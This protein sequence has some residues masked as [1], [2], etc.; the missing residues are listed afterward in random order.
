MF[1]VTFLGTS[2]GTPTIERGMP[3]IAIKYEGELL[4]W[5]CGEG[6][7]RQ[8]MRY[9]VGY[10]SVNAIFITHPHLDHY[11]GVFGLL[12][13]LKM[14]SPS[15]KPLDIFIPK[16]IE[17]QNYPFIKLS[18][19]KKGLLYLGKDFMVSAYPVKHCSGSYGLIF[20][21][22]EKLKFNEEKAHGLG[23]KGKLFKEI[24]K[25]GMVKTPKGKILLGDISWKKPGR[26]IVYTGD[27]APDSNTIEA[28]RG[29]DLLIHEGTFEASMKEEAAERLHST[30]EDAA[31]IAK[32]AG[33]KKLAIT[34]V[35]CRYTNTSILLEESQNIF[36]NTIIA[37]DGLEVIL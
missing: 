7:Q 6:T 31:L 2:A 21:E 28:A 25:K 10:G 12:E 18:K 29:A 22:N 11:L 1:C 27:C 35:S 17:F 4:L 36:P 23:I 13:T 34:H 15:P 33:A 8:L 5:D 20:E 32:K 24:Q 9:K 30:V 3:A 19:M 14:S 37:K 26:K 16:N